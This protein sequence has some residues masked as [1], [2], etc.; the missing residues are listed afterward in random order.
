MKMSKAELISIIKNWAYQN[1]TDINELL[2]AIQAG[3]YLFSNTIDQKI[4]D[5]K[6]N[7]TIKPPSLHTKLRLLPETIKTQD[8]N[9]ILNV[10]A[11]I[12]QLPNDYFKDKP[13]KSMPYT[14]KQELPTLRQIL[15]YLL[16]N[17]TQLH[18]SDIAVFVNYSQSHILTATNIIINHLQSNS[19]YTRAQDTKSI[20]LTVINKLNIKLPL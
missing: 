7:E 5:I 19:H 4:E 2:D 10:L 20:I 18:P 6:D 12:T 11:T 16:L 13:Q 1:P 15:I 8:H 14:T 17:L 9:E 3:L